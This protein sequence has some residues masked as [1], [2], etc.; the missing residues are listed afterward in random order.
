[1]K[2]SLLAKLDGV[3][4]GR[5]D[6]P[7]MP[8]DLKQQVLDGGA[9]DQKILRAFINLSLKDVFPDVGKG[10]KPLFAWESVYPHEI[11]T[12]ISM[13]NTL[14]SAMNKKAISN[15]QP[16]LPVLDEQ[17]IDRVDRVG[18]MTPREIESKYP[19][20]APKVNM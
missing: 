3:Q 16:L 8:F 10:S 4:R 20:G 9:L 15:G 19:G 1:M 7:P 5:M 2:V 13:Y 14:N 12:Y 6:A 11:F 18:I 17:I